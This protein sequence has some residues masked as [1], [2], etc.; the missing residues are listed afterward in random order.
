MT[1]NHLPKIMRRVEVL[2][3]TF[4]DA[5]KKI[6]LVGGIVRDLYANAENIDDLDID[7]TTDAT[8]EEI[9]KIIQPVADNI[10]LSGQRFGTIGAHVGGQTVEITT[11]RSESYVSESR[12]PVVKFSMEIEE[13]LSRRDF[14]MNCIAIDL[15]SGEVIDPFNG[16]EDFSN[17]ILRTPL[18]PEI[19]F[20]EDPLRMLRAAR[21]CARYGLNLGEGVMETIEALAPRL[22]IVSRERVRDEFDKLLTVPSPNEGVSIL[23]TSG[24]FEQ[25]FPEL[26]EAGINWQELELLENDPQLRMAAL[27]LPLSNEQGINRMRELK[28]SKDRIQQTENLIKA[29]LE[30]HKEDPPVDPESYRRWHVLAGDQRGKILELAAWS[31]RKNIINA[32]EKTRESLAHEL[33]DFSLPLSGSEII[34]ILG[35]TEGPEIGE[36]ISHLFDLRYRNGPI[37]REEAEEVIQT[38]WSN[39]S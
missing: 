15:S 24:L 6:Y 38:W 3:Q 13:D 5:D 28:Y 14:T 36:A 26:Q 27:L 2:R 12:K 1:F 21:F 11:H 8:P 19:S 34:E 25:F 10:W 17:K 7:L 33:E 29:T 35:I 32:M 30:T 4:E 31:G 16:S 22:E 9:K 39:R 18:D 20:S 37:G 23:L